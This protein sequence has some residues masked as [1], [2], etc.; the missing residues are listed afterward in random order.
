VDTPSQPFR[1][2]G[3]RTPKV[4]AIDKVTGRAQFGA[5]VALPRLLIGKVLRGP[6]AHA[7]IRRI[8]TSKAAALPGVLAIITGKDL[9]TLTPSSATAREYYLSHEVLARD[10]WTRWR[11]A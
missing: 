9:P 7:R 6:Y 8:D 5:D 11:F 4:D 2:I 3:R 10:K 1:V